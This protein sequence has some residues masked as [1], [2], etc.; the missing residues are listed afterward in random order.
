ME[1]ASSCC[2]GKGQTGGRDG[3]WFGRQGMS[4]LTACG[5]GRSDVHGCGFLL[6][7][8]RGGRFRGGR[9]EASTDAKGKKDS[10]A[11]A[12]DKAAPVAPQT[13]NHKKGRGRKISKPSF[14]RGG[15]TSIV[16]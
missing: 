9:R 3:P 10:G 15:S 7:K 14:Q 2:L 16:P 1:T 4:H 5:G 11:E 6:K 13:E 12:P 8:V